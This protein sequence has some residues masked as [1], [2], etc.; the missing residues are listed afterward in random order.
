[1]V[2]VNMHEAKSKLSAL[3]KAV[4]TGEEREVL[5]AR[6]GKPVAK[7]VAVDKPDVSKRIGVADGRFKVP[8][9]IDEYEDEIIR[10]FEGEPELGETKS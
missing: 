1:M 3:I 8:D 10:M 9:N 6:K 7:L 2:A 4:E 5:I